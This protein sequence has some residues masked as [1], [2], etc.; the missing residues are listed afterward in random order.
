M[1]EVAAVHGRANASLISGYGYSGILV[2]FLARSH[3]LAIVPVALVLGGINASGGLLQRMTHLPDA[4]VNVL[5]GILFV[6]ILASDA[7][8]GRL[9][10]WLS[11]LSARAAR[12]MASPAVSKEA[13]S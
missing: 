12:P 13:T 2:A 4:A 7:A 3:P 9:P 6:T 1:V 11:K 5:Q 10:G 8:Y